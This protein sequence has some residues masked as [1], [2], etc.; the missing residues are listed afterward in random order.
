[1]EYEA[2]PCRTSRGP[3]ARF[4]KCT[5]AAVPIR[6]QPAESADKTAD[7]LRKER[8][9]GKRKQ[10]KQKGR[11]KEKR[12]GGI[13]DTKQ[14]NTLEHPFHWPK[15]AKP[16]HMYRNT[17]KVALAMARCVMCVFSLSLSPLWCLP[18]ARAVDGSAE[19]CKPSK[20]LSAEKRAKIA[21]LLRQF[22]FK[23]PLKG[24]KL[25]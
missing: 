1:M 15:H 17:I 19:L 14:K 21:F 13:L 2:T 8:E 12:H 9:K 10:K 11:L 24:H 7:R 20:T 3:G 18:K 23:F 6:P 16:C 5:A 25:C 4:I 22:N